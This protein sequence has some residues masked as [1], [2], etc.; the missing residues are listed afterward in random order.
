MQKRPLSEE[1][2]PKKDNKKKRKEPPPDDHVSFVLDLDESEENALVVFDGGPPEGLW[3]SVASLS[4]KRLSDVINLRRKLARKGA[5]RIPA[6]QSAEPRQHNRP[7]LAEEDRPVDVTPEPPRQG[8]P[9]PPKEI[10]KCITTH[11]A[12]LN[13][14][15]PETIASME[16]SAISWVRVAAAACRVP[17]GDWDAK[18]VPSHVAQFGLLNPDRLVHQVHADG[19]FNDKSPFWELRS[20]LR[21]V[22]ADHPSTMLEQDMQHHQF[23]KATMAELRQRHPNLNHEQLQALMSSIWKD[24]NRGPSKAE[25]DQQYAA[26][27]KR[28]MAELR[29][30]YPQLSNKKLQELLSSEWKQL[31]VR[32]TRKA[33]HKVRP[34]VDL[35]DFYH[36]VDLLLTLKWM[37][38]YLALHF[39]RSLRTAAGCPP[40]LWSNWG[41]AGMSL[42]NSEAI[43]DLAAE[44]YT[45]PRLFARLFE[46]LSCPLG[47]CHIARDLPHC[48]CF[49]KFG[50]LELELPLCS[51]KAAMQYAQYDLAQAANMGIRGDVVQKLHHELHNPQCVWDAPGSILDAKDLLRC[52]EPHL[53]RR[54]TPAKFP[55]FVRDL[56]AFGWLPKANV[57]NC[58]DVSV[59][60]HLWVRCQRRGWPVRDRVV[61]LLV[62]HQLWYPSR[63][64]YFAEH[65]PRNGE[66]EARWQAS[67][68]RRADRFTRPN[69]EYNNLR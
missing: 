7:G 56:F 38:L 13:N 5:A 42:G 54:T 47:T 69:H 8:A 32:Q 28:T 22:V 14:C 55:D 3:V 37:G 20:A 25:I 21:N 4:S 31:K 18:T 11:T 35:Y 67:S 15:S 59:L 1:R 30:C 60:R 27:A 52:A 41:I 62:G 46:G 57:M 65:L 50:S 24:S 16:G 43:A 26:F 68:S 44:G 19:Q 64:S 23:A 12:I 61:I 17:I 58:P 10:P 49:P 53:P 33:P 45:S 51:S 40:L 63:V 2:I 39:I 9:W 66:C 48:S 34:T 29:Q 6:S 36:A